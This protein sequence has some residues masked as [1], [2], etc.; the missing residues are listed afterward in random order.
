M[1]PNYSKENSDVLK[2]IFNK[3]STDEARLIIKIF[4]QDPFIKLYKSFFIL[5]I[6]FL[7]IILLWPFSFTF[8]PKKNHV[9]W[10][11]GASGLHFIGEGQVISSSSQ[12]AFYENLV[13]A[14]GFSLEVWLVPENNN[15]R[16][17]A[18]I[19]SYSLDTNYRNFTL[20]QEGS[21]LIMRLR[22]E[23]TNLNGTEPRLIVEDVFSNPKPIHI[24]V[25]YNFK[26]QSV[27]VNGII[28]TT[29]I[30]PGGNFKN[31]DPEY[32]LILGNEG[33]GDRPWL[34][35][36]SYLA[37]YNR[38]LYAQEVRKSYSEVQHIISGNFEMLDPKEGL[39]ARYLFNEKRGNIV[40]NSGSLIDSLNLNI[41][42][43]IQTK[44]KPFLRFSLNPLPRWG[45][46]PF[47]EILLNVLLFM[48]LGYLL[49][50][51]IENYI[52]GN[53]QT[54]FITMILG[55]AITLSAE[56]VQ[57]FIESRDSSSVDVIANCIGTLLG[58]NFKLIYNIFLIRITK[59]F[60][61]EY[62][63]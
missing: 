25:S 19:V 40:T 23:N 63:K 15:Q 7:S 4:C 14:K 3:I 43:K 20:G 8:F 10:R 13:S 45:S 30:I 31:W 11:D 51:N 50:A 34:G 53:L 59:P 37:I 12:K 5:Y 61:D 17:P 32:P 35:E 18:R 36:I 41:P 28:R 21:D 29:S 48:P 22:T 62:D 54:I 58:I 60:E 26:E 33:T 57:Y 47:Y 46:G 16:G 55:G 6:I 49:H 9:K 24:V 38:S 56:I 52:D 2:K 42:E 27:F 44:I 1:K 39:L